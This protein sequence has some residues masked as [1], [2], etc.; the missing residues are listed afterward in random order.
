ML[1]GYILLYIEEIS[2][3][4]NIEKMIDSSRKSS[5]SGFTV[6]KQGV[7]RTNEEK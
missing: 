4:L 3:W 7:T 5:L 6:K 2:H 1:I